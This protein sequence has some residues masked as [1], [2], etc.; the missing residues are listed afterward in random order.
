MPWNLMARSGFFTQQE[1]PVDDAMSL[2]EELRKVSEECHMMGL[3]MSHKGWHTLAEQ[4]LRIAESVEHLSPRSVEDAVAAD[5]CGG[6]A[7]IV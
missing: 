6:D 4:A 2:A 7:L 1:Q 3:A 5:P